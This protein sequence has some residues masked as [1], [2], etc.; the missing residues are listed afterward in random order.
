MSRYFTITEAERLL[1]KVEERIR[2][3]LFIKAEHERADEEIRATTRKILVSGGATVDRHHVAALKTTRDSAA[4][5]LQALCERIQE[6]GC[7][8]KDLDIGLLDFPTLYHGREVY[9]C[10]RFGEDR[11]QFWHQ[12]EDGF[13]G[14][15]PVDDEFLANHRGEADD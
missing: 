12:V 5:R 11:I 13:K 2:E 6:T 15:K 4:T 9:L 3:V 7:L 1:P 10:W 14:R 8:V